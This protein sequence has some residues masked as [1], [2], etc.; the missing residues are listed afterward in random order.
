[1]R[2]LFK[3]WPASLAV[4]FTAMAYIGIVNAYGP[5]GALDCLGCHDPHYAKEQK[6]FTVSNP[7]HPNPRTG[8][9]IDG[10]SA[11]CLGCH[12]LTEDGGAGVKPIYLHMTHPVNIVPNPRIANVPEPLLRDGILQ[13]VSCHDPHPSNPFWKYL[14]ADTANGG[15]VQDFCTVCHASKGDLQAEMEERAIEIFSS[16]NEAAGPKAFALNDPDLVI[17]NATPDYIRPLGNYDN[18]LAPAYDLIL[19]QGWVWDVGSQQVPESLQ[20]ARDARASGDGNL[21][22]TVPKETAVPS[23]Q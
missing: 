3:Y 23:N 14:R 2:Y 12:N 19:T 18:S 7:S 10:I 13:C 16:M 17:S 1:M 9:N 8:E 5:H 20:Q 4:A 22:R 21:I 11:L 15:Q 6:L